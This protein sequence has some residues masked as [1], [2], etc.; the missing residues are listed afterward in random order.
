MAH[1]II[2]LSYYSS[3]E[4]KMNKLVIKKSKIIE[5]STNNNNNNDQSFKGKDLK[6]KIENQKFNNDW[7]NLYFVTE[8]E[9]KILRLLCSF[10]IKNN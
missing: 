9:G 3:A 10:E 4:A 5:P 6:H 7:G 1:S 2:F 8:S